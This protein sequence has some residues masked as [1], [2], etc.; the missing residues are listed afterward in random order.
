MKWVEVGFYV[1]LLETNRSVAKLD[2]DGFSKLSDLILFGFQ[3]GFKKTG[4]FW[5]VFFG[6]KCDP[7]KASHL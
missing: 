6:R 7:E 5:L 3:K 2:I 1:K 4:A